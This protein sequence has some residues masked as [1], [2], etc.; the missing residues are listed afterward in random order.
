MKVMRPITTAVFILSLARIST[1]FKYEDF[2]GKRNGGTSSKVMSSEA[3]FKLRRLD[4]VRTCQ[5]YA[6]PDRGAS[7]VSS[8]IGFPADS[9]NRVPLGAAERA[10]LYTHPKANLCTPTFL[11]RQYVKALE[12]AALQVFPR[13]QPKKAKKT[14][15]QSKDKKKRN[16]R[17]LAAMKEEGGEVPMPLKKT[18]KENPQVEFKFAGH[19][20]FVIVMHPFSRLVSTYL[21]IQTDDKDVS[22]KLRGFLGQEFTFKGFVDFLIGKK[23]LEKD[24]LEKALEIRKLWAP[25]TYDCYVCNPA[26]YAGVLKLDEQFEEDFEVFA[27]D[28]NLTEVDGQVLESVTNGLMSLVPENEQVE[29]HFRELDRQTLDDLVDFYR[30]DLEMFGYSVQPFYDLVKFNGFP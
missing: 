17:V 23:S 2:F 27:D 26:L 25:Y 19:D 28:Y 21:K 6:D 1:C 3:L 18:K 24:Q 4:L 14:D 29:K 11:G 12:E 16:S 30:V 5:K 13:P 10:V 7:S 20:F 22:Q 8:H 9:V 15:E